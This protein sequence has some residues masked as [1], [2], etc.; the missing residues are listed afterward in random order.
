MGNPGSASDG[1]YL[2]VFHRLQKRNLRGHLSIYLQTSDS[3][4][5]LTKHRNIENSYI[6]T[7]LKVAVVIPIVC[8]VL[9][10]YSFLFKV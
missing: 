8:N 5:I 10:V 4:E 3:I 1:Y 9:N 7:L 6:F 2:F